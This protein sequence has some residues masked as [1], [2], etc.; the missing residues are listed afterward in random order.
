MN[1]LSTLATNSLLGTDRRP[2]Q[3]PVHEGPL[4]SLL[5]SLERTA[6]EK[7]LLQTAGILGTCHLAGWK[8]PIVPDTAAPCPPDT[9]PHQLPS[10]FKEAVAGILADGPVRLQAEGFIKL[11][12]AGYNLPHRSLPQALNAARSSKALRP[13]LLPVLGSRGT[14][15]AA[16]N[17]HWNYASGGSEDV[18]DIQVWEQGSLE[19]RKLFLT[20]LRAQDAARAR[21]LV[22]TA[23]TTEAAR[24]RSAFIECLATGLSLEDEGLLEA[25]L[26][27]KSKDTRQAAAAL[28][29]TLPQSR[30]AQRMI[31]RLQ[32][33]L[34]MEKKFLRGTVI[35]LEPP[36]AYVAEWKSDVIEEAKPKHVQLGER[37]WW[38]H[39]IVGSMPLEW[40]EA[41]TSLSPEELIAWAKKS[42]WKD[43]LILGWAAALTWQKKVSW[44]DAFLSTELPFNQSL[45][46]VELLET[47]PLA[48]REK[49]FL[50]LFECALQGQSASS[51]LDRFLA[52]MPVDSPALSHETAS[53]LL[54]VLKKYINSGSG[55]YDWQLRNSLVELACVLP[56]GLFSDAAS[57][58]DL[59]KE[60]VQPFAEAIA[61]L[62]TVLDQRQQLQ[63]LKPIS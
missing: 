57:G 28:L 4:G 40:W 29:S 51:S 22:A 53:Q 26:K 31:A 18:L 45:N 61:R 42:D 32:P 56:A 10:P 2:P 35:T 7:A 46:H 44:A 20:R 34:T 27:D 14:W 11:A 6:P 37:A 36:A 30:Y 43:A 63:Y 23:L 52:S 3:W 17:E 47:L 41:H 19:Q 55:R 50:R 54:R 1:A 15:L 39:Q 24:E 5:T 13:F 16:Q 48:Q 9:H 21:E 33:C 49:H 62:G 8:P 59:T 58:W 38:L 12:D 60:E 25:T